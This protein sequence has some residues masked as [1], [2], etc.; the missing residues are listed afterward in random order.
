MG[1]DIGVLKGLRSHVLQNTFQRKNFTPIASVES[2]RGAL[3]D[4]L[5][6]AVHDIRV[7]GDTLVG[8]TYVA[9]PTRAPWPRKGNK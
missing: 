1:R 4:A 5:H 9:M 3:R 2:N 7:S 8:S 6:D